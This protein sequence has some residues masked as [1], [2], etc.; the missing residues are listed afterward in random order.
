LTDSILDLNDG[1]RYSTTEYENFV[2]ELVWIHIL[3]LVLASYS[4][5]KSW[6]Y[7]TK[8]SNKYMKQTED[9]K[10]LKKVNKI[11]KIIKEFLIN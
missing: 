7:V 3:I 9:M 10:K 6:N 4:L 11:L 8:F 1:N 5:I 2:N